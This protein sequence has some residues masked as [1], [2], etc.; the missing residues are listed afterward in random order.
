MVNYIIELIFFKKK[1]FNLK[2]RNSN[3]SKLKNKM[4]MIK[5]II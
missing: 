2:I 1:Y 3:Q 4:F 5:S